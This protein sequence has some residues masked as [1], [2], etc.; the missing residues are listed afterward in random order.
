MVSQRP[1]PDTSPTR[2][3]TLLRP[4]HLPLP[5]T[6]RLNSPTAIPARMLNEVMYCERLMYLE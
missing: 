2:P 6:Q 3:E 1:K 5:G 4:K